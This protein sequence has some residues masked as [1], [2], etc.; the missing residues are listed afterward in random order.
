[1]STPPK[2]GQ[3]EEDGRGMAW[4]A[5]WTLLQRVSSMHTAEEKISKLEGRFCCLRYN[6]VR[7]INNILSIVY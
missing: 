6:N 3:A 4:A 5:G 2:H 7:Q 1:M